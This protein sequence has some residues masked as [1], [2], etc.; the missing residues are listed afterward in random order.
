LSAPAR[1]QP[2][3]GVEAGCVP[4]ANVEPR[5]SRYATSRPD[6]LLLHYTGMMDAAKAVEWLASPASR[7]SCHY[8]VDE[9][10][11]VT[12]LVPE[13]LRAWHAGASCWQG[14]RDI[15]SASIG[16]EIHNPGHELG[17]HEFPEPQIAAVI[18]LCGDICRRNAIAAHRVLAHSDVAPERKID[19]GE[20]FPWPRLAAEGVGHWV[21]PSPLREGARS[22]GPGD[23]GAAV[24][25][26]QRLLHAYGYDMPTD[27]VY[28]TRTAKVVRGFQLHFRPARADGRV[29]LST[30]ATA[31][32]LIAALPAAG[33]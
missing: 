9:A 17:Y 33:A 27:G 30:L 29:D 21:P 11:R 20:K 19:P 8:L 24:A 13:S 18:A 15:N 7:V 10:G 14:E 28:D 32:R 6:I 3:C 16:I 22:L 23:S 25:A 26:A 31:E 12:Q 2:D 5:R 1:F 4:A